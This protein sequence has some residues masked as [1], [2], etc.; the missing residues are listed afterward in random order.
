MPHYRIKIDGVTQVSVEGLHDANVENQIL[1]YAMIC[2]S[3]GPVTIQ[4]QEPSPT[5][6]SRKNWKR[7][8]FLEQ[9]PP[10]GVD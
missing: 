10:K 2:R 3:D 4:R 9:Y 6:P 1:H 5:N 7:H 8:M